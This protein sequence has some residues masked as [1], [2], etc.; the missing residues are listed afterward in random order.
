MADAH[1]A[2][3]LFGRARQQHS[4][5][6]DTKICQPVTLV[7]FQFFLRRDQAAVSH[8]SAEFLEDAGVHEYS[9]CPLLKRKRVTTKRSASLSKRQ[10]AVIL[11]R[12]SNEIANS[13]SLGMRS[14]ASFSLSMSVSAFPALR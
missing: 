3:D 10:T 1:D 8:N 12:G 2:L 14:F 6:Q 7:G 13:K 4:L 9:V 5:R 11:G